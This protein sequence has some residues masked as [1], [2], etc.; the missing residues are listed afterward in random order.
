[1]PIPM[2]DLFGMLLR[3]AEAPLKLLCGLLRVGHTISFG[4][5]DNKLK[6]VDNSGANRWDFIRRTVRTSSARRSR[7]ERS[8]SQGVTGHSWR[9]HVAAGYC[10]AGAHS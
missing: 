2:S 8:G 7:R 9:C 1:M 6:M 4:I 5:S 10:R 3:A